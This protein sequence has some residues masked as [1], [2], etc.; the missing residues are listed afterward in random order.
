MALDDGLVGPDT[1]GDIVGLD[2]QDLLQGIGSAVSLQGPNFHLAE[3]LA[4]ELGLAA[5]GLLG[6]QGVGAGGT[7]VDLIVNQ[8]V[9][10]QEVHIANGDLVVEGLAGTAIVQHALALGVQAGL[11]QHWPGYPRRVAPSKMGVATL[12]PSAWA[13]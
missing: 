11:F 10:L 8:V 5:Q 1:A 9:Q 6:D 2:G 3:A 12:Q 7:G 13:A 4:A